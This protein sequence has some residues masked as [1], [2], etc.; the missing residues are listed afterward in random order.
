LAARHGTLTAAP[1]EAVV[2]DVV[3]EVPAAAVLLAAALEAVTVVVTV[4]R[5][6]VVAEWPPGWPDPLDPHAPSR[7]ASRRGRYLFTSRSVRG[8]GRGSCRADRE[9]SHMSTLPPPDPS[10]ASPSAGPETHVPGRHHHSAAAAGRRAR[11]R[12]RSRPQ[13]L[14]KLDEL[15]PYWGPQVVVLV[16][17]LMDLVLPT[18]LTLGP[19]WLLPSIEGALLVGLASVSPH[20]TM[21]HHPRRRQFALGLI[22]LVSAVN[23]VS[24]VRLCSE[25]INH[26][27][28][29]VSGRSLIGAGA[30]LWITNVLLF[31][32]W[33]WELDRGGPA[34]REGMVDCPPDFLFPQMTD[35]G[36]R[37]CGRDWRPGLV[38]YLYVSFTN[39]TAFSPTDTMPLTPIAKWLMS[40]QALT[41]LVTVGLVVARAV[42]ILTT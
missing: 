37:W 39:A 32:I 5:A 11:S 17:I 33:Y 34:D 30:A 12:L 29:S 26:S 27:G 19:P 1:P 13:L 2:E 28:G 10:Q 41:S 38:D 42:N 16:A 40:A 18:E 22:G 6:E 35:D 7:N 3:V 24:L 9:P 15:S 8:Q 21:R 14:R 25:L 31:A 4:E 36:Q 23:I 20:P